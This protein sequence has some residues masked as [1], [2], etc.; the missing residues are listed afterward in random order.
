MIEFIKE[1]ITNPTVIIVGA[2]TLIEVVPIKINP[3]K[4]LF[5]WIGN[6][7]VGDVKKDVSELKRDFEETKA[8]DMRW[9]ILN[10]ANS[11]RQG[12]KHSHDE[13]RHALTQI[14]DYEA[15]TETKKIHNGV[16]E[17]DIKYLRALYQE[18]NKKNDFY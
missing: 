14:V 12:V 7:I 10:F 8:Q 4:A 17:E 15:Y 1:V 5:S 6:I 11:C 9:H 16:A 3:W 13:W 18:R 2:I